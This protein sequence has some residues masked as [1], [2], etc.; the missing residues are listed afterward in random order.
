MTSGS[1]E[2]ALEVAADDAFAAITAPGLREWYYRLTP[3]GDFAEGAHIRWVDLHGRIAEESDVDEVRPPSHLSL[4]TRFVFAPSF[5]A[6]A[7]HRTDWDVVPLVSGCRVVMS[8]QAGELVGALLQSE[9]DLQLRGLRLAV[10][11]AARAELARLNTI[12]ELHVLDVTPDRVPDYQAFFDHDAFADFPAWQACYCMETHR[13]QSDEEWATRTAGDNRRDMSAMISEGTVSALLAYAD[14]KVVGWCNYGETT[15]LSGLVHRYG[16]AAADH[17]GVGSVACFVIAPQYRGHG[18]A[19]RLLD[20]AIERLRGK[21][22]RAIEAYPGRIV[23]DSAQSH[24]RGPL[25]MFL[26]AGFEAYR[27]TEHYIVVRKLL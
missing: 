6:L 21:G 19:S 2:I 5:A 13:T 3:E 9:G 23:G 18:I 14:G 17:E 22:L 8:W 7:P 11:P 24:Y 10:D 16:L 26:R 1:V 27:E 4:R 15:H 25:S 12:G 20:A